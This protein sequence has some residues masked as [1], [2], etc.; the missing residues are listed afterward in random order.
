MELSDIKIEK[1]I[2]L[3]ED[4]E[5]KEDLCFDD[6]IE[7]HNIICRSLNVRGW[8]DACNIK[9]QE[10]L[11]VRDFLSAVSLEVGG[12]LVIGGQ[13]DVEKFIKVN[14]NLC[15]GSINVGEY[16]KVDG[17][18]TVSDYLEVGY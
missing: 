10:D 2:K 7:A 1:I 6:N 8:L 9:T 16:L 18:I 15:A 11:I 17:R 5:T 4:I 12:E 3:R 13:I 14:G